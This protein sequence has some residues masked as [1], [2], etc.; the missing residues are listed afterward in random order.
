[1]S[2]R[3]Q[4]VEEM[5]TEVETRREKIR[6]LVKARQRVKSEMKIATA[7]IKNFNAQIG[8]QEAFLEF[9]ESE[10]GR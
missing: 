7:K 1:M 5:E 10:I 6:E 3:K 9:L 4:T 2:E 8:V